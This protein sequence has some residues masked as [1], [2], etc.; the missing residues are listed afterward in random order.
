MYQF[1]ALVYF[2][3][4]TLRAHFIPGLLVAM[5]FAANADHKTVGILAAV[6]AS[7]FFGVDYLAER[8]VEDDDAE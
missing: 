6:I 5:L 3:L 8:M 2:L 7:V 4:G 1:F